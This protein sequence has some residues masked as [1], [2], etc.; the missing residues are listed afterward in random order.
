[1]YSFSNRPNQ[2]VCK[3]TMCF[4]CVNFE[5]GFHFDIMQN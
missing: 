5:S 3:E 2:I 4:L 1:M